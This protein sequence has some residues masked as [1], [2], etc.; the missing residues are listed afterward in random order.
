MLDDGVLSGLLVD[1]VLAQHALLVP[2]LL[3]L[4]L[5]GQHLLLATVLLAYFGCLFLQETAV[6]LVDLH[7]LLEIL[8]LL[9]AH[10]EVL[11]YLPVVGPHQQYMP[12]LYAVD[13][14]L[15]ELLHLAPVG[16]LLPSLLPIRTALTQHSCLLAALLVSLAILFVL[17]G[18][19]VDELLE[20]LQ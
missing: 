13:F 11:L 3:P 6:L 18:V 15:N 5:S 12:A 16:V 7:L 9:L 2:H 8:K 14:V 17:A 19:D 1:D 10:A 20:L 4:P